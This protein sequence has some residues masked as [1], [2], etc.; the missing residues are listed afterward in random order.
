MTQKQEIV[1]TVVSGSTMHHNVPG[2]QCKAVYKNTIRRLIKA[3]WLECVEICRQGSGLILIKHAS[4]SSLL[5]LQ[6]VLNGTEP[7]FK[8]QIRFQKQNQFFS[9]FHNYAIKMK[10]KRSVELWSWT[11]TNLLFRV[12]VCCTC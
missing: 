11:L 4:T 7:G 8:C 1:I 2:K 6:L 5:L 10:S 3:E 12:T 9:T